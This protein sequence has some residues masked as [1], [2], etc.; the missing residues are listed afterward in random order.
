MRLSEEE[1]RRQTCSTLD[2]NYHG[3]EIR[4]HEAITKQL[5]FTGMIPLKAFSSLS[6]CVALNSKGKPSSE[7]NTQVCLL[8]APGRTGV[9]VRSCYLMSLHFYSRCT[10]CSHR[11]PCCTFPAP[12]VGLLSHH[13]VLIIFVICVSMMLFF[14]RIMNHLAVHLV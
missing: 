11:H 8:R 12:R 10:S 2:L 5:T 7:Y 4:N 13:H 3:E 9:S 6:L 14:W 1:G